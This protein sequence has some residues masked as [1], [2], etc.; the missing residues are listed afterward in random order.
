VRF[1][2]AITVVKFVM[3]GNT[4]VGEVGGVSKLVSFTT[5]NPNKVSNL[6]N[7][8]MAADVDSDPVRLDAIITFVCTEI[9]L[10]I[11]LRRGSCSTIDQIPT[12]ERVTMNADA[13]ADM[14]ISRLTMVKSVKFIR[15]N[16]ENGNRMSGGTVLLV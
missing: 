9:V 3:L 4:I 6:T 15:S 7:S 13:T 2:S 16:K 14:Y 1:V 5:T 8:S 12:F 11:V 10:E